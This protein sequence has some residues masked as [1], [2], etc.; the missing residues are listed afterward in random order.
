MGY[1]F[2]LRTLCMALSVLLLL[3]GC[4]S[5]TTS[6]VEVEDPASWVNPIIGTDGKGH[7]FPGAAMPFGMVQLSPDTKFGGWK[8]C[9]GYHYSDS[10]IRGFSHTH[11]SGTGVG[12]LGDFIVMPTTGE[13]ELQRG[14]ANHPD[15]G[16][17]SRFSHEDES[18]RPGYYSVKLKDYGIK[19]QLTATKRAGLHK[20]TFPESDSAHIIFDLSFGVKS[21]GTNKTKWSY[22]RIPND[23][24]IMGYRISSKWAKN[25]PVYFA[26]RCSKPFEAYGIADA[27]QK[28]LQKK[29]WQGK[30]LKAFLNFKTQPQEE[31]LLKVGISGVSMENALMNLQAEIPHWKFSQIKNKAYNAWNKELQN[32]HI[33]A[34]DSI[35]QIFYTAMYHSMIH[36]SLYT[37]VNGEYAGADFNVHQAEDFTNYTVFSLWDTYRALHP[38]FTLIQQQRTNDFIHSMLE[39]Q[40]QFVHGILPKWSFHRNE[41]WCMIGYH[42][43]PVIADAY[44][45]GIRQYNTSE[46]MDAMLQTAT[47]DVYMKNG[48]YTELGYLPIDQYEE[49]ASKTLEYAFDDWCVARMAKEMGKDSV[50]HTFEERSMYYQHLYDSATGFMRARNTAGGFDTR[51][52]ADTFDPFHAHYGHDYTEANAW[53]YLWYVPHDVQGLMDLMGGQQSFAH[54]LDSLFTVT[55]DRETQSTHDI[56]GKIGQYAHGN[57]PSHHIAYLYND[58]GQPWKTQEKVSTIMRT[59]Y[60]T[61]PAGLSGNEDCGQMS[62]WYIFSAMGFYPVNPASGMYY[63]GTPLL[64]SA[65]VKLGNGK[66]FTMIAR[67]LSKDNKYIQSATLNGRSYDRLRIAHKTI[68]KGGTLVFE[69]GDQ[70]NK[71]WGH[72][73]K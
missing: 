42:A 48:I 63:I 72:M 36:P 20:Y 38:L 50:Y 69:M 55:P 59:F 52:P 30:A 2:Y 6:H 60:K 43:V 23:S 68:M 7:T 37:D 56:S 17:R 15:S 51:N 24:T 11:F 8:R 29:Q 10:T 22:L 58:A 14:P 62:A 3:A 64:D 71:Q 44:L 39:H 66:T 16:Y 61:G 18:A 35:K 1:H 19:A 70:P 57:E 53:Q 25:R 32:I 49:A 28:F 21:W 54:K 34:Q 12:D 26:A 47:S 13:I 41:T 67:N 65:T 33:A 31:I 73:N 27:N 4:N 46:A 40:D 9:S 5:K 45:K